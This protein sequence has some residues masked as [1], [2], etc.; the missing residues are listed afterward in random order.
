MNLYGLSGSLNGQ[1][2]KQLHRFLAGPFFFTPFFTINLR[3]PLP[4]RHSE[5]ESPRRMG[6]RVVAWKAKQKTYRQTNRNNLFLL[7]LRPE[8]VSK[9]TRQ[10]KLF[11][12]DN[13]CQKKSIFFVFFHI[14]NTCLASSTDISIEFSQ[15]KSFS[16]SSALAYQERPPP[17]P[18]LICCNVM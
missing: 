2:T 9:Q 8:W 12:L 1:K 4:D 6:F 13:E 16:F 15:K 10:R 3:C 17:M 11:S 14:G 18:P 7:L 5:S